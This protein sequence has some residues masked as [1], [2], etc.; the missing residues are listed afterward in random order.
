[1]TRPALRAALVLAAFWSSLAL[2]PAVDARPLRPA[3]A[4]AGISGYRFAPSHPGIRETF[5]VSFGLFGPQSVFESEARGAAA[6]LG[7]RLGPAQA[8]V[9]FNTKRSGAATPVALAGAIA[10]AGAAMDPAKDVLVVALTSH[11]SPKGVSVVAGHREGLL[12]PAVVGRMLEASGARYRVLIVSA[13]YSGVFARALAG[14]RTLVIT[15]A[16]ADRPSFGCRDG[17]TWTYFGEA[18]YKQALGRP[19]PLDAAFADAKRLVTERERREGFEPSDPQ[20]AG[21][22]EVLALLAQGR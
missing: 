22:A 2:A 16:S 10:A 17:A 7:R 13:C 5:I 19:V 20:I 6:V 11:G 14:P 15:A 9:R 18:F 8:V 4:A 1:V 3:P 12:S 21:G